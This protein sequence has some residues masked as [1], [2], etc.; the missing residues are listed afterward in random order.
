VSERE[1]K[2]ESGNTHTDVKKKKLRVEEEL[3]EKKN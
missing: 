1:W 2:K 3:I